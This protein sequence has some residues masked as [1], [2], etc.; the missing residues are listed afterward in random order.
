MLCYATLI[1]YFYVLLCGSN[2]QK[3]KIAHS[4][5][6]Y[7]VHVVLINASKQIFTC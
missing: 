6:A 1:I 7:N 3:Q 5:T 4:T 2:A